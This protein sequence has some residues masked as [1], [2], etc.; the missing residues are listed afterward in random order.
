MNTTCK[1]C[2]NE[3]YHEILEEIIC[4]NYIIVDARCTNCFA[5][6]TTKFK[7]EIEYQ[8]IKTLKQEIQNEKTPC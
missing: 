3:C 6:T 7:T 5:V 2:N 8:K 1:N 4:R